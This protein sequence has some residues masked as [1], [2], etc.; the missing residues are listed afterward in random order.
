MN[1]DALDDRISDPVLA[2]AMTELSSDVPD[3][4]DFDAMRRSINRRAELLLARKR[5]RWRGILPKPLIPI[6]AAASIAFALWLG[7]DVV[8]N[9]TSSL[10]LLGASADVDEAA[11]IEAL[12]SDLSE[13]EFRL[14]VTG[15]ANPEALLTFAI[16]D[17]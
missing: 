10:R 7:P 5:A 3:D 9:M 17:R 14:L 16:G 6:V 15:R 2:T 8:N 4:V 11:L 1:R 13:R 12:G